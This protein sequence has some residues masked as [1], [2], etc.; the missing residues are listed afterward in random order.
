MTAATVHVVED[1]PAMRDALTLL[2]QGEG[3]DVRSYPSAEAFL[4]ELD[5]LRPICLPD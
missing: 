2:L 4:I 1:D 5:R 3:F